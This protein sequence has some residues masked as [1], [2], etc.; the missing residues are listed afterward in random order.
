MSDMRYARVGP[1]L[2]CASVLEAYWRPERLEAKNERGPWY[3][4]GA[5]LHLVAE[6]QN[7]AVRPSSRADATCF[8]IKIP[9]A[10]WG[11]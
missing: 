2:S 1:R 11:L 5:P 6:P 8:C 3:V 10:H 9:D 4:I 7:A